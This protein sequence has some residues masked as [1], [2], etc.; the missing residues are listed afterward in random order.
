MFQVDTMYLTNV[1][2]VWALKITV[3]IIS[4]T[5]ELILQCPIYRDWVSE[6]QVYEF[7]PFKEKVWLYVV[8]N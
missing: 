3:E 8:L 7:V 6:N 1:L 2:L 5:A 4:N